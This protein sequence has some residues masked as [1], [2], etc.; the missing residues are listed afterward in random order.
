MV[1]A[2]GLR[3]EYNAYDAGENW[4]ETSIPASHPC[5]PSVPVLNIWAISWVNS[6][7]RTVKVM[8][9]LVKLKR[10][11]FD[12]LPLVLLVRNPHPTNII[13]N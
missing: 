8:Q 11:R 1:V 4:I 10:H 9:W 3:I 5:H 13:G 12:I 6:P 7:A 2:R